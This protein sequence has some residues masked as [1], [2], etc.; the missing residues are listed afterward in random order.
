MAGSRRFA[1]RARAYPQ[2]RAHRTFE[3][4]VDGAT[5]LFVER[6]YDAVQTPDIAAAAGVAVGTFYRYF[7]DKLEVYLEV[8]GRELERNQ[9]AVLHDLTPASL[10]GGERQALID[11]ALAV[12][13]E[14]VAHNPVMLRSFFDMAQREPKVAEL[15]R[16]IDDEARARLAAL[17]AAVCPPE[18]IDDPEATAFVLYAS[19][20]EC[21]LAI[22]G[23]RGA[24]PVERA[25]GLRALAR[26][27]QRALFS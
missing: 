8:L 20:L 17:I 24:P 6:P 21:A 11:H 22:A 7:D 25:R 18:V 15:K 5:R 23:A 13:V 1:G 26:M 12:L 16:A 27:V 19:A 4:L 2:E 14:R 10:I 9:E 3:S